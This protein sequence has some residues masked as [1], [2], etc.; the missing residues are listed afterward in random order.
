MQQGFVDLRQNDGRLV[1]DSFWPSFTDVMTVIVMIFLIATTVLIVKNWELVKELEHRILSEKA[2]SKALKVTI[3]DNNKTH[4]DLLVSMAAKDQIARELDASIEAL[5]ITNEIAEKSEAENITLEERLANSK[6]K[7][8][9]LNL[10]LLQSKKQFSLSQTKVSNQ[11]QL[12]NEKLQQ[13]DNLDK[14]LKNSIGNIETKTQAIENHIIILNRLAGLL[15]K[16]RSKIT[17]VQQQLDNSKTKLN[18][19]KTKVELLSQKMRESK[20]Y[21][22]KQ[23]QQIAD[24]KTTIK[25]RDN[26]YTEL[27]SRLVEIELKLQN[28]KILYNQANNTILTK[29]QSIDKKELQISMLKQLN[30]SQISDLNDQIKR[31][32]NQADQL[33]SINQA[34]TDK[35]QQIEE[36]NRQILLADKTQSSQNKKFEQ[37]QEKYKKLIRPARSALGKYVVEVRY[38]KRDGQEIISFKDTNDPKYTVLK[39]TQLNKKLTQLK[40]QYGQRLYVKVIIPDNSGLSYKE[41]WTFMQGIFNKYDYYYQL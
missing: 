21:I 12:I 23:N 37:L 36:L 4:K 9:L 41:A 25:D 18:N 10:Q 28:N 31:Y 2:V 16:S 1:D 27:M 26:Q 11:S 3:L 5:Q 40:Q 20:A 8:K 32:D 29:Q 22:N 38:I 39:I 33:E 14:Q 17:K 19:S 7:L 35:E 13:I 24:D 34:N 30:E 15:D 6:Q